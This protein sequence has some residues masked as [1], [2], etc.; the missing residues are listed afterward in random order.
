MA[1]KRHLTVAKAPD[2]EEDHEKTIEVLQEVSS[3]VPRAISVDV[4]Y[5]SPEAGDFFSAADTVI[6]DGR[7][8][9]EQVERVVGLPNFAQEYREWKGGPA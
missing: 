3:R 9:P 1:G 5:T 7:L 2:P 4:D 6:E 8:T